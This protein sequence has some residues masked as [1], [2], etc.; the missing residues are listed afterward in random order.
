MCDSETVQVERVPAVRRGHAAGHLPHVH[1]PEEAAAQT[2]EKEEEEK[3]E[4]GRPVQ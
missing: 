1:F 3:A 4:S 2:Q